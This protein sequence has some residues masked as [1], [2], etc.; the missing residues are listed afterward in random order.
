M[1]TAI[2]VVQI[3]IQT[4]QIEIQ[5]RCSALLPFSTVLKGITNLNV[6]LNFF[7]VF[8]HKLAAS[9]NELL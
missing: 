1:P 7:Y 4:V 2:Q 9:L 6:N 8:F 5:T 3:E